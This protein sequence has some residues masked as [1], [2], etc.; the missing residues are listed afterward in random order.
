M[1]WSRNRIVSRE[2]FLEIPVTGF[3]RSENLKIGRVTVGRRNR[4][5]K[6]DI[7][8]ASLDELIMFVQKAKTSGI[9]FMNLFLHSYSFI[10]FNQTFT[11][12]APDYEDMNKFRQFMQFVAADSDI[13]V[14]T[15][16]ELGEM[17]RT[18]PEMIEGSDEVPLCI[19]ESSLTEKILRKL[20]YRQRS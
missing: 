2:G 3:F 14:V 13:R 19:T 12:F 1:T 16:R 4:F 17:S 20:Q 7:D 15:I 8:A 6:T 5:I 11:E 18:S 9:R 10:H